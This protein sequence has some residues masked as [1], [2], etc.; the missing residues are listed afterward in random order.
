[1]K[2]LFFLLL[3]AACGGSSTTPPT[4]VDAGSTSDAGACGVLGA[5]AVVQEPTSIFPTYAIEGCQLAYVDKGTQR[6][7]LRDLGTA[8]E[9]FLTDPPTTADDV[10]RRPTLGDGIVAW[11]VGGPKTSA[12]MVAVGAT[13]RKVAGAFDHAGEPRAFGGVV[14]FTGWSSTDPQG[15]TDVFLYDVAGDASTLVAGGAGQQRFA[16]VN[17]KYVAFTDFSED[18]DG[19]FDNNETDLA[20]V[21]VFDRATKV[22]TPR[23]MVGKEAFPVLVG[24]DVLGYIH[25]SDVH[26]EP[27]FQAF[28]VRGARVGTPTSSDVIIADVTNATRFW[29]PSGHSGTLDWIAPDT[30]GTDLLWRAPVDGS[31]V[32]KTILD[33]TFSGPPQSSSAVTIVAVRDGG[34]SALKAVGR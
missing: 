24:D 18:P 21:V 9:R 25:W 3:L 30:A 6:L 29:L 15:D 33:A 34:V 22:A 20:D 13:T 16:D 32:K 4:N 19:R 10:P 14:V 27:K 12:V 26:P 1:M 5:S 2:R 23:K 17:A 11:E 31:A 8:T 7:V 28:G